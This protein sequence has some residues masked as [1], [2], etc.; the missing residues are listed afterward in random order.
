[1]LTNTPYLKMR[2][3]LIRSCKVR[4]LTSL[5]SSNTAPESILISEKFTSNPFAVVEA[6][7]KN[8]KILK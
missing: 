1:M 7:S 6:D 8:E 2:V 3:A 5:S 4:T